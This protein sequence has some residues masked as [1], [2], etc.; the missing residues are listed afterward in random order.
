[1]KKRFLSI[2]SLTLIICVMLSACNSVDIFRPVDSLMT[3]PLYY[4]E[5]EGL[6]TA[7]NS[8]VSSST[9]LCN[10]TKGDHL[11]AITVS[12]IDSD[13]QEE[14]IV[15][16]IDALE[17]NIAH[18]SIF[19]NQDDTWQRIGDFTGYGDEVESLIITD[20]DGDD[21]QEIMAIWSYSGINSGN[22]FS[23][24]RSSDTATEYKELMYDS[25]DIAQPVDTDGDG[26]FEIFYITTVND[27]KT[28]TKTAKLLGFKEGELKQIGATSVDPF[29][30]SYTDIKTERADSFAPL[31]IFIDA[32]KSNNMM[33][34]EVIYLDDAGKLVDPLFDPETGT[35][36]AT[37]RYEKLNCADVNGDGQI[38]IPVQ[39]LFKKA[40]QEDE[41]PI[42]TTE[43]LQFNGSE[44]VVIERTFVN[45][46]DGYLVN[47]DIMDDVKLFVRKQSGG[48]WTSWSVYT[49]SD[50]SRTGDVLFTIVKVP[51][52]RWE[53]DMSN[54]TLYITILKLND[55]VIS[56]KINQ[57]GTDIGIDEDTVRKIVKKLPQ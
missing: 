55:S 45:V 46:Q 38:E 22:V 44:G 3:P 32:V 52:D 28:V 34:T 40:E 47:L 21:T 37:L 27:E 41:S 26:I 1:M 16:Y 36:S 7:F 18:F 29:V 50:E 17:D 31:V 54:S 35:N 4:S 42:Y 39:T 51:K 48:D 11:S 49:Q 10:P 23:V 56:V 6:V 14:G 8:C 13:G 15:F 9:V 30:V 2:V 20:I 24:Y 25:C 12:D 53:S 43:W 57:N 19:Q 5:Y 33:I